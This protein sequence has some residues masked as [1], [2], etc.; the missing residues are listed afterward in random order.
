MGK[1]VFIVAKSGSGKSTALRNL[2]PDETF[3]ANTDQKPLPFKKFED[4]YSEEKGNYLQT[5]DIRKVT[6][7]LKDVHKN[8]LHI[9]TFVVDTWS[10]IMTDYIMGKTFRGASGFQKWGDFAADMYDLL[11]IIND[12]VRG[13]LT[14]YLMAHPETHYDDSG[15]ALE[16]IAVQGKQLEKFVPESFSSIVLYGEIQT[17]PGQPNKHVFRTLNSGSDTCKTPIDMFE[18]EFIDNDLV[19]VNEA[20]NEYY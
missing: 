14:V 8:Q 18:G 10:R 2:N 20:I 7:A 11:N 13:D 5:S 12:K 15:F 19:L 16:R 17:A 3:I 1:L 4:L 6:S 9:K